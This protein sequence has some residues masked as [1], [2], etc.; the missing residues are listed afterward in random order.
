MTSTI[1]FVAL[2]LRRLLPSPAACG[3]ALAIFVFTPTVFVSLRLVTKDFCFA[4]AMLAVFL[5]LER[6]LANPLLRRA[7]TLFVMM[8]IAL[9]I[10]LDAAF[11]TL[12]I[13]IY[14]WWHLLATR[15]RKR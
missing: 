10:R 4:S 9:L 12:P 2:L 5:S 7:I 11:A 8:E 6:Y 14:F 1:A 13:V 3:I 15:M